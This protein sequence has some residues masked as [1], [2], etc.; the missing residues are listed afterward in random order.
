MVPFIGLMQNL[1]TPGSNTAG[2]MVQ[3][4]L[5]WVQQ[6]FLSSPSGILTSIRQLSWPFHTVPLVNSLW[7]PWPLTPA[8]PLA[9]PVPRPPGG[10]RPGRRARPATP[11]CSPALGP[12]S[13]SVYPW[14]KCLIPQGVKGKI[15]HPGEISQ[16][17]DLAGE[18]QREI[19]CL[20][21]RLGPPLRG[22]KTL[23]LQL[24]TGNIGAGGARPRHLGKS[25]LTRFWRR[26]LSPLLGTVLP[27]V[28][29][30]PSATFGAEAG[31]LPLAGLTSR[32]LGLTLSL[33][34]RAAVTLVS[35][36][37][38]LEKRNLNRGV[39]GTMV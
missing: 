16:P 22:G 3:P 30:S 4:G 13:L 19:G 29:P 10:G 33:S 32:L 27:Q 6:E 26:W 14:D 8:L 5:R 24:Q 31:V 23:A 36:D 9:Q 1:S 2:K 12:A 20:T 39:R 7:D 11:C 34:S 37:W 35:R 15:N 21:D 38:H 17:A 18:R 25:L 28:K